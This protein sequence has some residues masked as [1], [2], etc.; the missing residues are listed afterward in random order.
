M[1]K[2][3]KWLS[4]FH[5]ATFPCRSDVTPLLILNTWEKFRKS[6]WKSQIELSYSIPPFSIETKTVHY[7]LHDEINELS[8]DLEAKA[9]CKMSLLS[10]FWTNKHWTGQTSAWTYAHCIKMPETVWNGILP[11]FFHIQARIWLNLV[12]V[13]LP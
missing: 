11:L 13:M 4:H 3:H 2:R 6:I 8:V 5:Y 1:A 7:N 10:Y 9:L 12:S